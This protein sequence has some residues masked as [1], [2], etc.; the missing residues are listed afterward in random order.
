MPKKNLAQPDK[1]LAAVCGLFCPSCRLYIATH[2]D[3]ERLKMIA[4]KGKVTVEELKCDGCRSERRNFYCMKCK[5]YHCAMEKRI[6]FCGECEDYPCEDLKSFQAEYP[7]RIEL[8]EAQRRIK[9]VGYAQWYKEQFKHYSCPKC[10][11]LNSAYDFT[12]RKCGASP[13]CA[14]VELHGQ[15][16]MNGPKL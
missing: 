13:S 14:Y 11:T 5:L 8:W 12:C 3:P 7:H 16:I 2:E 4:Q 15:G 6:G 1:R 10:R 9:E